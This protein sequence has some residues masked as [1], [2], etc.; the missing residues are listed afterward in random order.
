MYDVFACDLKLMTT[1]CCQQNEVS[2][3]QIS[4]SSEYLFELQENRK[5]RYA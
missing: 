3:R 5:A 2:R 1:T 4:F